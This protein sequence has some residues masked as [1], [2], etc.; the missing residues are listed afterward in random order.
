MT[1]TR[2]L[3]TIVT[4][5]LLAVPLGVAPAAGSA[6]GGP[7]ETVDLSRVEVRP[8]PDGNGVAVRSA[9]GPDASE[10]LPADYREAEYLVSG[11]AAVYAGPAT[12]PVTVESG[13]HPFTTRAL[14]RLPADPEDF[15]GSVWVEPFNTTGGPELDA[16]WRSLGPLI[17]RRGD[18]WVGV[19]V[20]AGQVP[21]LQAFDPVR[22]ADIDFAN[23][24]YGWDALRAVGALLKG[25]GS[26]S[27]LPDLDVEHIYLGGYSQSGVDMA[28]FLSAFHD[29]TRLRGG[30]PVYDGYLVGARESNLSPLQSSDTIIPQFETARLPRVD[31]PVIEF[32]PQT[33]VEGFAVEVPTELARQEGL[34]GAD[35]VGT[36]TFTYTTAG[37]ATVRRRDSDRA[38]NQYRL[39]EI[40][41]APHVTGVYGDCEGGSSFPTKYFNRAAGAVLA[42]W[43]ERGV[44]PPRAPRIELETLDDVSVVENDEHGNAI[45]GVRSPYVDVPLVTYAVHSG[46]G[47]TCKLSG[48]ETPLSRDVLQERYG[49]AAGYLREFTEDLDETIEAGF[50]LRLDRRAIL[51]AQ[52]ARANELFAGS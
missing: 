28:T 50:L 10:P 37:G 40:P 17:A 44:P 6:T 14:V 16:L 26:T 30:A 4:G 12:G 1:R 47:P 41:G 24:D 52:D 49:D 5:A 33:D 46:P 8:V 27:P 32:S 9:S 43:A 39:Y 3:T 35:E 48:D 51:E 21:R 29:I 42:K 2:L 22:Y 25:N 23:N 34:A 18:A 31:V 45:G 20:R 7:D 19:T 15:S 36:P 13:G 38:G 11:E